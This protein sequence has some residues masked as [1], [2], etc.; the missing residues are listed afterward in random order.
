MLLFLTGCSSKKYF[1]PEIDIKTFK[2]EIVELEPEVKSFRSKV[3]VTLKDGTVVV[4]NEIIKYKLPNEFK[5]INYTD[6][7]LLASKDNMLLIKNEDNIITF[8]NNIVSASIKDNLLALVYID[9]SIELYDININNSLFVEYYDHSFLNDIK[10]ANPLFVDDLILFPTLDAKV[11]VVSL[12]NYK[13][14]KNISVSTNSDIKNIIYL[15][16]VNDTLIAANSGRVLSLGKESIKTGDYD[17]VDIVSYENNIY[18]AT[19][20]G[21][22]IM[23]DSSLNEKKSI[24]F[25]FAKFLAILNAKNKIFALESQGY[26]IS[27]DKLLEEYDLFSID[28]D[29]ENY[30]IATKNRLFFINRYIDF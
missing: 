6:N 30:N 2:Y 5:L 9:N 23:L 19:T 27:I 1:T 8:R 7:I 24:K 13:L 22:L 14:I 21:R 28:F 26:I 11:A 20:D 10:I 25:K 12:K 29:D 3:G 18:I 16:I 4:P 15:G 17:I